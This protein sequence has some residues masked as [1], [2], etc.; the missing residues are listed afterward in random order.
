MTSESCASWLL[1]VSTVA[2]CLY[3]LCLAAVYRSLGEPPPVFGLVPFKH[4][5][6]AW[7]AA[8]IEE[9]DIKHGSM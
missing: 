7:A 8:S 6:S 4:S 2:S 5:I 9:G 3:E 1:V